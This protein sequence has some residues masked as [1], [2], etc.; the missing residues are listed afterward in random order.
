MNVAIL[1][2]GRMGSFHAGTLSHHPDVAELRIFDLD[3]ARATALAEELRGVAMPSAAA[4]LDGADA[5]VIA[6]P[7]AEHVALI[8]SCV[9]AGVPAFT[10]KPV[11][12]TL[13]DTR[14]V[15][16]SVEQAGAILQVGF[17]RRFDRGYLAA[18]GQIE[19]GMLGVVYSFSM[20]SRDREPPWEGYIG[21]SG[22][23]FRDL[24]IHDFDALRWLS[25]QEVGEI[26]AMGST[27]G[28]EMFARYQDAATTVMN[29]RLSGG[30]LGM[31]SGAR[32]NPAGYDI[33]VDVFGSKGSLVIGLD[34]RTPTRSVEADR[35]EL[36]GP[37]YP[38][39]Y[40]RFGAAYRAE[41]G[42]FLRVA[43]GEAENP[44]TATD[45]LEALRIA[46]AADLSFRQGRP[47]R[48]AELD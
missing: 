29:V 3:R 46:E 40:E 32:H 8:E 22:G 12:L 4:A 7:T 16:G 2:V 25:G 38:G 21:T 43:R 31:I 23:I 44:C 18:R 37:A 15:V 1:G 11:A 13:A 14:R 9:E 36:A 27:V 24:H 19:A 47:V 17:Q 34:P 5:A 10:E 28:Q 42:H 33:R 35:P 26:Q 48:L 41:L 6:T 45:A 39:F 30:T 20:I